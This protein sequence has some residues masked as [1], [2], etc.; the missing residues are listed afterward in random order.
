MHELRFRI[1]IPL[2]LV[3]L[4]FACGDDGDGNDTGNDTQT[5]SASNSAGD[6]SGSDS[7][8]ESATMGSTMTMA[9]MTDA[10]TGDSGDSTDGSASNT[11]TT[12]T[13]T[14]TDASSESGSSGTADSGS[15]SES[16]MVCSM[17]TET[18]ANGETCCDGLEC[19][20]GIPIPPGQEYCSAG[21]C[22]I[23]DRDKKENFATVDR[24]E[25]LAKVAALP[26]TTWNYTFEDPSVRHIG[27]MAQDFMAAFEVGGSDKAIFQVDADG[28]VLASVQAL[29]AELE[30]LQAENAE[31][32]ARLAKLE[33]AV[34]GAR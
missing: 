18:C 12:T 4:A 13:M 2:G 1:S 19:C 30:T 31:L 9:T 7:G 5:Q 29:H 27:P 25:V 22:P 20:A 24:D 26:I 16:G 11:M 17:D 3:T 21:P 33:A 34:G 28:V 15:S 10:A 14:T 32:R 23:S 6:D 8:T